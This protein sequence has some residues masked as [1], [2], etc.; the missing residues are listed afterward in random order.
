[1]NES[2]KDG[3]WTRLKNMVGTSRTESFTVIPG[4]R[5]GGMHVRYE[6]GSVSVVPLARNLQETYL[7]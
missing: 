6:D 5:N 1:M 3:L 2:Q 4:N 7:R